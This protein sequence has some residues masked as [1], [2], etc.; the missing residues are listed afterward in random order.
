MVTKQ[1]DSKGR[2]TLNKSFAGATVLVEER[3]DGALVIHPAVTIPAREAWL[4]K[5]KKAMALVMQGIKEARER[6]FAPGP[7]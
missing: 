6:K 1:V 7:I 2:L 3:K 4:W 5:N